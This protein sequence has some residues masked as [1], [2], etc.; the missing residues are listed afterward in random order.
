MRRGWISLQQVVES[1]T[2]PPSDCAPAFDANQPRNLLVDRKASHEIANI[3]RDAHAGGERISCFESRR[4]RDAFGTVSSHGLAGYIDTA[5]SRPG[6][7]GI[8]TARRVRLL[9][10]TNGMR[11]PQRNLMSLLRNWRNSTGK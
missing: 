6:N 9:G 4:G 2:G 3:D 11:A 8:L 7:H 10:P 5:R 1:Q